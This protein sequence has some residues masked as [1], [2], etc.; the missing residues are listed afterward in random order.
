MSYFL[1][2]CTT[3]GNF[4]LYTVRMRPLPDSAF[5]P[6]FSLLGVYHRLDAAKRSVKYRK[7]NWPGSYRRHHALIIA[8]EN[9][10]RT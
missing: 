4:L 7:R 6:G 9:R 10:V 3:A 2:R 1:I 5:I 8:Y